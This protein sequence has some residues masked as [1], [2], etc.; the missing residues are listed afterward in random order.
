MTTEQEPKA[1][2]R[3]EV[4]TDKGVKVFEGVVT[5]VSHDTTVGTRGITVK[6]L[7]EA[8]EET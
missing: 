8:S 7:P 6:T 4:W 3:V 1:G 2:E 5:Q